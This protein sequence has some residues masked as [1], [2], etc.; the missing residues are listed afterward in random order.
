MN[1]MM[2]CVIKAAPG[3]GNLELVERAIPQVGPN[4]V[5]VKVHSLAVCGTDVHIMHWNEFAST[6]MTPPTIIGHEFS[7][8]VVECGALVK[9]IKIGDAVSAETHIVCNTCDVCHNGNA[10]VCPHTSVIGLSRDG[11]LAEY[12]SIPASNAVVF[13]KFASW[14]ELSLM[15]PYVAAVHAATQFS[16]AGKTVAVIGC[17]PIGAMGVGIAKKCGASNVIAI[18]PVAERGKMALLMGADSL[19]DPIKE[20][21]AKAVP[22]ANGGNK[23]DVVLDF[24]GNVGAIASSLSYIKPEGKIAVLGLSD[25]KLSFQLD[26]FVYGALPLKGLPDG[27]CIRIG[28]QAKVFWQGDWICPILLLIN[29][30]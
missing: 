15:E 25:K 10:H 30:P 4:D 12:I 24:S 1:G 14:E 26:E 23:I 28:K 29:F 19:I 20:D 16:V 13:E 27:E 9:Q 18:E 8:E 22:A 5:L 7:G 21:V 6:R 11:A 17:G 2:K 3:P